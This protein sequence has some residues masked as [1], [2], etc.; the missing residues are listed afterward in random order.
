MTDKVDADIQNAESMIH[1]E[2]AAAHLAEGLSDSRR[3][4][5]SADSPQRRDS[6]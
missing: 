5:R 2:S 1:R 4:S 3:T 6:P